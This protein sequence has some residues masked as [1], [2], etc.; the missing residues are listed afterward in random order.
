[1]KKP[2]ILFG[3]AFAGFFLFSWTYLPALSKYHDLKLQQDEL[4]EQIEK[5]E[6]EVRATR[7]ERDLLKNDPEYLEKVIRDEMGLVKPG[8]IIYKFV[9][10]Q[11]EPLAD[12]TL[13][14]AERI[15]L[16]T[17]SDSPHPLPSGL[18]VEARPVAPKPNAA[19]VPHVAT[20]PTPVAAKEKL[21]PSNAEPVYPRRE[22]R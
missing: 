21:P 20:V 13:D 9:Q 19:S 10:D 14:S 15:P 8:E 5:F 11:P 4:D 22:T 1:M 6:R 17:L 3:I 16:S 7:E 18:T 2:F 12:E